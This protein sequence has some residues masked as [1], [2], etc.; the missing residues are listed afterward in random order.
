[1]SDQERELKFDIAS[2]DI[3]GFVA[4]PLLKKAGNSEHR[5][6]RSVYF[7]TDDD[8]LWQAGAVVR[9]RYENGRKVQT[10][11]SGGAAVAATDRDED[12]RDIDGDIPD[13]SKTRLAGVDGRLK[14][15]KLRRLA[16]RFE[17]D[18]DRA[19]WTLH[20]N[21]AELEIALDRGKVAAGSAASELCEVEVE[22][23]SGDVAVLYQIARRLGA[24]IPLTLNLVSKGERGYRLLHDNWR[25]PQK[26]GPLSLKR[27]MG[28]ADALRTIAGECMKQFLLN[29][30]LL[31]GAAPDP[32]ALH[33]ARVAIRRLRAAL[34]FFKDVAGD[35]QSMGLKGE[36]KWLSDLLGDA[37]DLDVLKSEVIDAAE[38][39]PPGHA[40]LSDEVEHR[41]REA[42]RRLS[43]ARNSQ[44]YRQ[45]LFVFAEW[46]DDGDWRKQAEGSAPAQTPIEDFAAKELKRRIRKLLKRALHLDELD[47]K[48]HHM[49]RIDAK[50]LRY[51]TEFLGDV[52]PARKGRLEKVRG[53]LETMQSELGEAHDSI[54]AHDFL[55]DLAQEVPRRNKQ[56]DGAAM[57]FAAGEIG[58][59][60]ER[61]DKD[62]LIRRAGKSARKLANA[63]PFWR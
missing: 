7:D 13:L 3:P 55:T 5:R 37:R 35:D 23:K 9:I 28:S 10:V 41:R 16:P 34:T 15:R 17:V 63:A 57:L 26:A 38:G 54:W 22:L 49:V 14:K 56:A 60:L 40:E 2:K 20:D 27:G 58:R 25:R 30:R 8:D 29:G 12:E 43:E 6:Q 61:R 36:L 11:K 31:D 45:L 47:E 24:D 19:T 4:H 51:V 52:Y 39:S 46:L 33:Q 32:E 62:K 50:K 48:Q 21:S 1:M 59:D 42:Y 18:V 44:R 53:A